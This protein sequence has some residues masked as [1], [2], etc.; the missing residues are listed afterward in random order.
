VKWNNNKGK[1]HFGFGFEMPKVESAD[2]SSPGFRE[3]L[4]RSNGRN[5]A[6]ILCELKKIAQFGLFSSLTQ[7]SFVIC[8]SVR[9][10][11]VKKFN[12]QGN[13]FAFQNSF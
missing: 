9:L 6:V 7:F 5:S 10:L 13:T 3:H 8:P 4:K 11:K 2:R 12:S 1:I